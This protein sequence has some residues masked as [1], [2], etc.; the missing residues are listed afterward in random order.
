MQTSQPASQQGRTCAHDQE[1]KAE[2]NGEINDEGPASHG[3]GDKDGRNAG[4]L[5]QA[6]VDDDG[7]GPHGGI[8]SDE[9]LDG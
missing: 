3:G 5:V 8:E 7:G 2:A 1:G 6:A 9:D 4:Y